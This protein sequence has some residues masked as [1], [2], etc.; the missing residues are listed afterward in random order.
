M[1]YTSS[2]N[3][4]LD[5]SFSNSAGTVVPGASYY[6]QKDFSYVPLGYII[7]R[8][9]MPS[10]SNL[11]IKPSSVIDYSQQRDDDF[12]FHL[13]DAL[14]RYKEINN[15]SVFDT[16]RTSV[17]LSVLKTVSDNLRL[18]PYIIFNKFA[19][20]VQLSFN[21]IDFVLDYDH[22]DPNVVFILSSRDGT[23]VVK[24]STLTKLE[25]VLRSF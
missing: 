22:E 13:N 15:G 19:T 17:F 7:Y 20:K 11:E 25:E 14:K 16:A 18:Q 6:L 21:G 2:T 8:L 3:A 24:E 4:Y 12:N 9:N 23:L 1:N 5:F 10:E